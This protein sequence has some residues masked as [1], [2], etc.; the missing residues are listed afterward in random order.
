MKARSFSSVLVPPTYSE[1]ASRSDVEL[2]TDFGPT[3]LSLPIISANMKTVTGSEMAVAMYK[4]GGFG[5]LHRFDNVK[6]N[7]EMFNVAMDEI[8]FPECTSSNKMARVRRHSVGVSVGVNEKDRYRFDALYVA[9]ARIFCIDIAHGHHLKMKQMIEYIRGNEDEEIT[10]VAGN[11]ATPQGARDLYTWGADIIKVGIGP[12]AVCTT[13]RSTGIGVPQFE[14]IKNIHDQYSKIPLIADGGCRD[15]GDIAIALAAGAS[16]V[17]LGSILAGH[18][19]TPGKVYAEDSTD[20]VNRRYYKLHYGS[21]SS[22]NKG[23]NRFVEG[24]MIKI[25]FKGHVKYILREIKEDLQSNISY[26]GC[27]TIAK[28]RDTIEFVDIDSGAT[29]ESE[30]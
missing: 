11:V 12:G 4:A 15:G 30:R 14:A 25:P 18:V 23:E 13:R 28:W 9:G 22:E 29:A 24:K 7:V 16:T 17:M 8:T 2:Y 27:K 6:D 21:A 5:F 20:M 3:I 26:R 19:E 10:I 1:I